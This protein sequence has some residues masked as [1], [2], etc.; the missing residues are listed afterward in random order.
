MFALDPTPCADRCQRVLAASRDGFWQHDLG[1]GSTWWSPSL[2]ALLGF[3][4]GTPAGEATGHGPDAATLRHGEVHPDDL[5]GFRAACRLAVAT[6]QPFDHELRL[7]D[8]AGQWRWVRSHARLWPDDGG[9][10]AYLCGSVT[11]VQSE[12]QAL[13]AL[14]QQQRQLQDEVRERT[15]RL[16]AAL[17]LAEQRRQEAEQANAAKSRFLAHMSHEIRTPLNGVLGLTELALRSAPTPEQRRYL[18]AAHQSGQAL[19][20]VIS[21]VLDLSRIESGQVELRRQPFDLVRALAE[22]LRAVMP[23]APQ[24]DLLIQFDWE[25]DTPTVLGDEGALRQVVT[26]LLGNALKFTERG[27]VSLRGQARARALAGA[28]A[29]EQGGGAPGGGR[30]RAGHPGGTAGGRVRALHAGGQQ[31]GAWPWWRR[32]GPGHRAPPGP[33][34]AGHAHAALPRHRRHRVHPGAHPAAGPVGTAPVGPGQGQGHGDSGRVGAA[35]ARP[36]LAGLPLPRWGGLGG[37]ASGP[38]GLADRGVH[39]RAGRL[40]PG[41]AG[42]C[43]AARP[44]ADRGARPAGRHRG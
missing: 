32:P 37:P 31:P 43:A 8:A 10:P 38:T 29:G 18:E 33:G 5:P 1:S 13:Q 3:D 42:R 6:A 19:Q 12:R 26:N 4:P 36:G 2:L 16:E 9:A 35:G 25:G 34:H 24:R 23:L 27:R 15:A 30:Q 21:D 20:Q 7:R 17:A 40:H 11:D 14:G 39:Q 22:T 41:R 28:A 44:G